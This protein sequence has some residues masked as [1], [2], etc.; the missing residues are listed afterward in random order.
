M[1]QSDIVI[2]GEISKVNGDGKAKVNL[3]LDKQLR[4]DF[5]EAVKNNR[6]GSMQTVLEAFVRAYINNPNKFKIKM[7]VV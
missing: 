1:V 6:G 5:L 3:K 7:E 4:G 2:D